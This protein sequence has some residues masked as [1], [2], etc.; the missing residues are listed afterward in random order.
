MRE[1]LC[2]HAAVRRKLNE[3]EPAFDIPAR[4]YDQ[5]QESLTDAGNALDLYRATSF[6]EANRTEL[7]E[8]ATL[9]L[10]EADAILAVIDRLQDRVRVSLQD[11]VGAHVRE[12]G[13]TVGHSLGRDGLR[14]AWSRLQAAVSN[15]IGCLSTCPDHVPGLPAAIDRAARELLRP[16]DVLVTRQEHA[17]SNYL[18][19]GYWPHA[20][21][22]TGTAHDLETFG[23]RE[24]ASVRPHWRRL[25]DLDPDEPRRVVEAKRDGVRLRSVAETLH[26]DALAVLRPRLEPAETAQAI[27]RGFRHVG[28]AYDF[29][30]DLTC[31]DRMVCTEVIYRAF[32]GIGGITFSPVRRAGRLTVAAEDL[33]AMAVADRGFSP[34][35]VHAPARAPDLLTGEAA[36]RALA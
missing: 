10:R 7:A 32:D 34:V 5:V 26:A 4:V 19:P 8:R 14:W 6:L 31:S 3:P 22:H 28:K 17:V 1:E 16:G 23:L 33:L 9:E 36:R 21:L 35:A 24:H 25:V 30:F 15:L 13:R 29:D 2:T 20:A 18:L 11:L 27:A 12:L